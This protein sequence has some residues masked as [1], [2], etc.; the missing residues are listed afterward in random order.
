MSQAGAVTLLRTA[1]TTGLTAALS[2]ALLPWRKPL[3]MHDPGKIVLDL[4][5]AV[6]LGGD[7][8]SDIGLLRAELGVFGQVASDP[9]VSRLL[10]MLAGDAGKVVTAIRAARAAARAVAWDRAG[11][12]APDHGVDTGDPL[13]I[14]LDATL[15]TA[16][17]DKERAAPNFK[18]G[19]GFHPLGAWADHGTE[20]TGEPLVMMLR[21]G[22]AGSNTAADHQQVLAAALAQLPSQPG[23]RVGRKVLVRTDSGGGT[24]EF[25]R[26]C[27]NRRL[28]YSVGFTLTTI[29]AAA[30]DRIPQHVWTPAYNAGGTVRDGAWVAEL[31]GLI[32]LTGWPPGMRVIV[33]AERPHPGA[34]L[35][36]T[37]RNG[38]R[39]TAFATNTTRGQLPDLELRHRRRARCEDRDSCCEGHRTAESAATRF[40]RQPDL[41][42]DHLLRHRTHRLAAN[43]GPARPARAP[44]GTQTA[45][46]AAVL[47]RRPTG[48]PRPTNPTPLRRALA[49]DRPDHHRAGPPAPRL[50]SNNP[51]LRPAKGHSSG[52]V[53][54]RQPAR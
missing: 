9:T 28:Q 8:L 13:V 26:Y 31:T 49:L 43:V 1:E 36:F 37:D 15:V 24:H 14:D 2:A 41:D 20:G 42:R 46:S 33:R 21:P 47:R 39:L 48:P 53:E 35:R 22:N 27:H 50:T 32:D 54:P 45:A 6:A 10:S 52:P 25:V 17:S 4:A 30:V 38:L 5:V 18:Q 16:H 40:R 34:Q 11:D 29:T 44:L 19:Y 23:Y 12:R 3:A 51:P 7:C